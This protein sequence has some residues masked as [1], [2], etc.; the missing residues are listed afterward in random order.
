MV[1][2]RVETRMEAATGSDVDVYLLRFEADGAVVLRRC[3]DDF[4]EVQDRDAFVQALAQMGDAARVHIEET[5]GG[6]WLEVRI[7]HEMNTAPEV[8]VI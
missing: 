3:D 7:A 1:L 6:C 5:P 2:Q 8:I 4:A